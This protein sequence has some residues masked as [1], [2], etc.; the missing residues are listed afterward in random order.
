[1]KIRLAQIS[2]S[3][4]LYSE[5]FI[6]NHKKYFD[7]D[8]LFYYGGFIPTHLEGVG[9]LKPTFCEKIFYYIKKLAGK[10]TLY[11]ILHEKAFV[12]SLRK[13]KVDVVFAE[14]GLTGVAVMDICK[15]NNIPL[16]T[17]FHGFDMSVYSVIEQNRD[18]YKTLFQLSSKIIAVS[19][20]MYQRILDLGCPPEKLAY[21]TYG[22]ENEFLK[23]I[24]D[25]S[26]KAFIAVG[27]FVN[28]KAPYY[29][30]IAFKKVLKKHPD[31]KLY[32]AGNGELMDVCEN[33]VR[34]WKLE[35]SVFLLGAMSHEDLLSY[36]SKVRAFVQHSITAKNGDMEGTPVAVLEASAS[37]LSVIS[38]K[39]AGIPDVIIDGLTGFLVEEHDVDG[40]A[41]KMVFILDNIEKASEM[42]SAG[43]KNIIDNYSMEIH[44]NKLNQLIHEVCSV[45]K[46]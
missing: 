16:I 7:A 2:P 12:K 14:Y 11:S 43:R 5:T 3:Q 38:T 8:V 1:M 22:P 4:N 19:K 45:E 40:M 33:M 28:K 37:A 21:I 41:D 44:I 23:I 10:N 15:R 24:P 30:I 26:E 35:N 42:G 9:Y 39:H 25:Y 20:V 13:N 34:Y 6:Q 36:Y 46:K 32:M 17:N 31:A 29:T 18:N 27:R